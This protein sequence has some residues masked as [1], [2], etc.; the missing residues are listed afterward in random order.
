MQRVEVRVG[1]SEI[2]GHGVLWLVLILVTLGLG[3]LVWP[4]YAL[5]FIVERVTWRGE[6]GT[7]YRLRVEGGLVGYVGHAVLW[8]LVILITFGL[9]AP[10]WIYDVYR[11]VLSQAAVERVGHSSL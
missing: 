10:F 8:W 2:V 11:V 4:Y 5:R 1:L 3:A 9:A 7:P 6:E